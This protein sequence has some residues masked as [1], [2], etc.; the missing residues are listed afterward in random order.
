MLLSS[1][2]A[3]VGGSRSKFSDQ[4]ITTL[5]AAGCITFLLKLIISRQT[6]WDDCEYETGPSSPLD[7]LTHNGT[8]LGMLFLVGQTRLRGPLVD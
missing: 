3:C 8:D 2:Q 1:P 5:L 6:A 4:T 7:P